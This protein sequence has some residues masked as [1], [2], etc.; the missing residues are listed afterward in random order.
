VKQ[1]NDFAR[2]RVDGSKIW[3]FVQIAPIASQRQIG[4]I[5]AAAML[6]GNN[7]FNMERGESHGRLRKATVFTSI[8]RPVSNQF[9]NGGFH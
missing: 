1:R 9:S 7:V 6:P 3:P 5:I 4:R 8:L 2:F